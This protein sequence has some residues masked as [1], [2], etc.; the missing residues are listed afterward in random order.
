MRH[1]LLSLTLL[2]LLWT[3]CTTCLPHPSRAHWPGESACWY[4]ERVAWVETRDG[5]RIEFED[6]GARVAST[7]SL[8]DP[9]EQGVIVGVDRDGEEWVIP[10]G[11]VVGIGFVE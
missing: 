6:G 5:R 7:A 9:R 1:I 3:G 4:G 2:P 11:E 10:V 8:E